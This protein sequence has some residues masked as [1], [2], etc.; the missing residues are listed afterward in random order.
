MGPEDARTMRDFQQRLVNYEAEGITDAL[1]IDNT[2]IYRDEEGIHTKNL[3]GCRF[4]KLVGEH[5][6]GE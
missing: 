5:G 1:L 2:G 3:G 4:V 6:W